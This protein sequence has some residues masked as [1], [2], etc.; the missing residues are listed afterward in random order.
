MIV[1]LLV[2]AL[3]RIAPATPVVGY[4]GCSN[5]AQTV[6]GARVD[7]YEHMWPNLRYGGGTIQSW[8]SGVNWRSFDM[9]QARYPA[10]VVWFQLCELGRDHISGEASLQTALVVIDGIRARIPGVAIYV[11]AINDYVAP[12]VAPKLGVN[13]PQNMRDLAASLVSG[14]YALAG[15]DVG[16]IVSMYQTPSAG[17]SAATNET[18]TDGTHPNLAG[19]AHLGQALVAFFGAIA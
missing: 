13:G 18:E 16:S 7:G 1:L 3:L 19:Q 5:T 15:P 10:A 11:S 4:V 6:A 17:A 12:H 2:A 9:A 8:A 14:G